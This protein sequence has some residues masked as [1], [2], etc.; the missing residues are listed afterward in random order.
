MPD[1]KD[2]A[3]LALLRAKEIKE[4]RAQRR[5]RVSSATALFAVSVAVSVIGVKS[6]TMENP[7]LPRYDFYLSMDDMR[8]P[9]GEFSMESIG[10]ILPENEP[11][12]MIPGYD[13]VT[14]SA[15]DTNLKMPLI[16]PDGNPCF[17]T[18]EI[19]L[20]DTGETLYTSDMVAPRA[21][22]EGFTAAKAFEE[23]EYEAV[24]VIRSY[25]PGDRAA[26]N[27]IHAEFMIVAE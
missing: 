20:S 11:W 10:K 23:G 6:L 8:V 27:V 2:I 22:V 24:M 16:N 18:F 7:V 3:R 4:Q 15:G 9:L 19:I 14:V 21:R 26:V 1:Y 25:E 17:L 13:K 12:L 5:K